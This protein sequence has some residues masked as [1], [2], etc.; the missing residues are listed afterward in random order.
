[1]DGLNIKAKDGALH[2]TDQTTF[3]KD[4]EKI[5]NMSDEEF[6]D[7]EKQLGFKSLSTYLEEAYEAFDNLKTEFDLKEWQIKYADIVE[8]R[9]SIVTPL[10]SSSAYQRTIN[11]NGEYFL[12]NAFAKVIG[13]NLITIVDG[14]KKKLKSALNLKT[15]DSNKGIFIDKIIHSKIDVKNDLTISPFGAPCGSEWLA[16]MRQ[17]G[18]RKVFLDFYVI[19]HRGI[20]EYAGV[21]EVQ[22]AGHK[23]TIFGWNKYKTRYRIENVSFSLVN[24]KGQTISVSEASGNNTKD[25]HTYSLVTQLNDANHIDLYVGPSPFTYAKARAVS[26]GTTPYWAVLCC[27]TYPCPSD[28]GSYPF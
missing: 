19:I 9:D 14:D 27:N 5:S 24:G 22:A 16:T 28:Y 13:G 17:D 2:F 10:I 21:V 26:R 15:S 23:K 18:K 1:M 20:N 8:L 12:E 3:F 4:I 11:R 6:S 7:F 25:T